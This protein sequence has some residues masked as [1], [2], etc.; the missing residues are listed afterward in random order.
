MFEGATRVSDMMLATME[1]VRQVEDQLK[2]TDMF[3]NRGILTVKRVEVSMEGHPGASLDPYMEGYPAA[4]LDIYEDD[5]RVLQ[6][7]IGLG[8]SI[9]SSDDPHRWVKIIQRR[10]KEKAENSSMGG[11]W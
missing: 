8:D 11:S 6:I 4:S 10:L 2:D 3:P 5:C 1:V 9:D 7:E